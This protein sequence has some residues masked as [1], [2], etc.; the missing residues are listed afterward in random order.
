MHEHLVPMN[1]RRY[2]APRLSTRRRVGRSTPRPILGVFLLF[3]LGSASVAGASSGFEVVLEESLELDHTPRCS[4]CHEDDTGGLDTAT[5]PFGRCAKD[6]GIVIRNEGSLQDALEGP[7]L[8]CD[9]DQDGSADVTELRQG[10]DP[11]LW[12]PP[13]PASTGG[14]GEAG[15]ASEGALSTSGPSGAPPSVHPL[16]TGCALTAP[17]PPTECFGSLLLVGAAALGLLRK[18]R[19]AWKPSSKGRQS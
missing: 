2:S 5:K 4:L 16:S 14:G 18:R 9:N 17:V 11:N 12:D 13:K 8:G 6:A 3:T 10:R 19:F 15:G 7:M 1:L